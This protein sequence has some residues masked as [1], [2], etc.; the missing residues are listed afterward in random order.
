M[1]RPFPGLLHRLS[2]LSQRR[3]LRAYWSLSSMS[4]ARCRGVIWSQRARNICTHGGYMRWFY[5]VS[6]PLIIGP[7][8]V[9]KYTVPRPVYEEVIVE[10]QWV[11]HPPG[12]FQ[13]IQN[14]RAVVD[15][16]LEGIPD[17]HSNP[18]V[19]RVMETIW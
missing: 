13:V 4:L 2:L 18:V 7:A 1:F 11:R 8:P 9:P 15:T 14:I 6:N 19:A 12:P 10:Q 16:T 5:R 17:V 3:W